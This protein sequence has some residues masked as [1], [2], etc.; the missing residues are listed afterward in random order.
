MS[1][2]GI[3]ALVSRAVDA[4]TQVDEWQANVALGV[5]SPGGDV[6]VRGDTARVF[7]WAS[8]SKPVFALAVLV[9]AEEGVLDLD[10]P[11]GPPGATVRHLLAHASG[12]PFEG[13][14][15]IARV[16]QRRVYS[17]SGYAV[18]ADVLARAAGM[19]WQEYL[20]AA[21]LGPL[22]M[23]CVIA[24]EPGAALHGTLDDLLAFIDECWTPTLVAP[25]T[26][27]EATS[28]QFPGLAGVTPEM[29]RFDPND[30][31]LGFELRDAKPGHWSG[32]RASAE[33]FGHWG[34]AGTFFFVDPS[35]GRAIGVACLTD[36]E[37]GPW[38]LEA[39]PRLNDAILAELDAR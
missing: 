11:A 13:D 2:R 39:W 33:T 12:L 34:G 28:V 14:A 1:R 31:G 9:A 23:A 22:G 3:A 37:F 7:R 32:E 36:R 24:E 19:S 10:D 26:L 25:E 17:N 5:V 30:W 4:L 35:P 16:G 27:M 8:V 15:P 6:A 29:G 20:K 18:L 21:V 38:A